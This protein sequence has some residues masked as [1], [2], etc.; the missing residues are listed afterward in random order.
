VKKALNIFALVVAILGVAIA[1][2]IVLNAP[3][4]E[5]RLE[6]YIFISNAVE[7]SSAMLKACAIAFGSIAGAFFFAALGTIVGRL[8]EIRDTLKAKA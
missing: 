7:R 4:A 5:E 8:E 1:L 2:T 3:P 6:G